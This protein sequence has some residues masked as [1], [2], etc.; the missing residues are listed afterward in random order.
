M[1]TSGRVRHYFRA[2]DDGDAIL[3]G[4][5]PTLSVPEAGVCFGLGEAQSYALARQ[6]EFPVRT[7]KL[8]ARLRVPTAEVRRELGLPVEPADTEAVAS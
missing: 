2:T 5:G 7:I 3:R 6:G 4:A 1:S 8:G